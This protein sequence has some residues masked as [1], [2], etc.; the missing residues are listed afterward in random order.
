MPILNVTDRDGSAKQVDV[1]MDGSLMQVL[2]DAGYHIAAEC[3][4]AAACGTCHVYLDEA[5]L[6]KL[7]EAD[8]IEAEMVGLLEATRPTSR[9]SCQIMMDDTL[10]GLTLTLAP[11][12]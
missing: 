10:D 12:E 11:E 1:T 9:L 3:G 4:G 6:S 5:W 7:P 2:R 8:E